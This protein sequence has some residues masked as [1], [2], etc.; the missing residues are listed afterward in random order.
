MEERVSYAQPTIDGRRALLDALVAL[1]DAL[2][3]VG[4]RFQRLA[5]LGRSLSVC[6]NDPPAA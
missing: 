1:R 2:I 5:S 3:L 4:A 6:R